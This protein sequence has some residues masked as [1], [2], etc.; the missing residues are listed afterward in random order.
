MA[1]FPGLLVRFRL[2]REPDET[3]RTT[4]PK[5]PAPG[6]DGRSFGPVVLICLHVGRSQWPFF[7]KDLV[8]ALL[9]GCAHVDWTVNDD[10]G[11]PQPRPLLSGT[12]ALREEHR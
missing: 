8:V 7:S 3:A 1:H 10:V 11:P 12:V 4:R 5:I 2:S 9:R 6:L